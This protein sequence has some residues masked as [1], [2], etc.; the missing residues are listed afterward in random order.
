MKV[1]L[2]LDPLDAELLLLGAAHV[3]LSYGAFVARLLR[4]TPLPAPL[5][6]LT[7]SDFDAHYFL[8]VTNAVGAAR[9]SLFAVGLPR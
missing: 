2:R 4:G 6:A 3:G 1:T 5:A 7:P 9:I 8:F